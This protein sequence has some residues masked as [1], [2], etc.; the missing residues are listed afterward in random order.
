M[1]TRTVTKAITLDERSWQLRKF[2][3]MDGIKLG[4]LLISKLLPFVEG[5]VS[6]G[7]VNAAKSITDALADADSSVLDKVELG[8]VAGILE[9]ISDADLN[10]LARMCFQNVA[11]LLPAGAVSVMNENGFYQIPDVEFDPQLFVFLIWEEIKFGLSDFFD[12]SRWKSF[13]PAGISD[14]L[15]SPA[16]M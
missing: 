15:A 13:L 14:S 10:Y 9:G 11:E 3:A 4:K 6:S 7:N 5:L 12:G 1:Q 8:K 2:S 16:A